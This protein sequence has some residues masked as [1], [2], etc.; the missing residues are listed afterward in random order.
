LGQIKATIENQY[1]RASIQEF[2]QLVSFDERIHIKDLKLPLEKLHIHCRKA[3]GGHGQLTTRSYHCGQ[4]IN[5][6]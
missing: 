1:I 2:L 3:D 6:K 5:G 4:G